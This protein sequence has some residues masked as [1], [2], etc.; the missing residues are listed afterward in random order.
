MITEQGA[1]T[2]G[3]RTIGESCYRLPATCSIRNTRDI[4]RTFQFFARCAPF[5]HRVSVYR[6][7]NVDA[8]LGCVG[9]AAGLSDEVVAD[10]LR[11]AP[12][13]PEQSIPRVRTSRQSR[14]AYRAG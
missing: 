4:V 9:K 6:S 3:S 11:L 8:L 5:A 10:K 12:P 14:I 2:S 7:F 13:R 1:M